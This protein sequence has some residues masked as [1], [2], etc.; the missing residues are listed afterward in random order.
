[1]VG[2]VRI[3]IQSKGVGVQG[4]RRD[5]HLDAVDHVKAQAVKVAGGCVV[6]QLV[7]LAVLIRPEPVVGVSRVGRAVDFVGARRRNLRRLFRAVEAVVRRA[8]EQIQIRQRRAV[9]HTQA[10]ELALREHRHEARVV[11]QP[12][13]VGGQVIPAEVDGDHGVWSA[14]D[15]TEIVLRVQLDA[16]ADLVEVAFADDEFALFAGAFERGQQDRDQKGD[17]R[18]DHQQFDEGEPRSPKIIVIRG[19]QFWKSVHS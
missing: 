8:E 3:L 18:D 16:G 10:G 7:E 12:E 4:Q 5:V 14:G 1:M 19:V 6:R 15:Q 9:Q 13:L 2:V 17:D 11:A